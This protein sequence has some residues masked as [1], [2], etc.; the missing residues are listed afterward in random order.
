MSDPLTWATG[1]DQN[2]QADQIRLLSD[3]YG[4]TSEDQRNAWG[5]LVGRNREQTTSYTFHTLIEQIQL[6]AEAHATDGHP[7]PGCPTCTHIRRTLAVITAYQRRRDYQLPQA[8]SS[9]EE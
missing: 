8:R 2:E 3:R 6:T 1:Y 5:N 9:E 7:R 4:L